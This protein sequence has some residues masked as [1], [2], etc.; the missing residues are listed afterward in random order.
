ML[1]SQSP[2]CARQTRSRWWQSCEQQTWLQVVYAGP[3]LQHTKYHV[4][5]NIRLVDLPPVVL[6]AV[7]LVRAIVYQAVGGSGWW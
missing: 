6:R 4:Q 1:F 2:T 5:D 3:C 7:C